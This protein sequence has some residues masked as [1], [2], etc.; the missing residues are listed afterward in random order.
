MSG[1]IKPVK[2]TQQNTFNDNDG[3]CAVKFCCD[4]DLSTHAAST[5]VGGDERWLKL[6][7]GKVSFVLE[8]VVYSRFFNNWF[9]PNHDCFRKGEAV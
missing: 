5:N 2:M 1:E 6:E 4:K 3:C 7:I 9:D 8:I